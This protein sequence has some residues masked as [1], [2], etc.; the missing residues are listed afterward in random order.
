MRLLFDTDAF[1]KVALCGLLDDTR[2]MFDV[3]VSDC[4]RLAALPHMLRRGRLRKQLGDVVCDSL[5]SQAETMP[6]MHAPDMAWLDLLSPI[7]DID[8]GE[9]QL[10]ALAV[11]RS[12]LVITG[13]KRAL[14]AVKSIGP[15]CNGLHGRVIVM[16]A[17]LINLILQ[18]GVEII[19]SRIKPLI[20]L[21][22]SIRIC[23][24]PSNPDPVSALG[25]YYADLAKEVEPLRLWAPSL[26][27]AS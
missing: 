25:S 5:I 22:T 14:K 19:R 6:V 2:A 18:Q 26:A 27:G 11:E 15:V 1:C 4:G 17:L 23:F 10:F 9:A 12:L 21:D 7:V 16:E 20:S 13:D 24:S 3:T 8:P